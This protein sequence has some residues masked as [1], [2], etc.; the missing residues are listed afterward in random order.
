VSDLT[1]AFFVI[2]L[3]VALVVLYGFF[4]HLM[5][6]REIVSALGAKGIKAQLMPAIPNTLRQWFLLTVVSL[7]LA[8]FLM[9][10]YAGTH[11]SPIL[12][13]EQ[14]MSS[15]ENNNAIKTQFPGANFEYIHFN[16]TT[17]KW[18]VSGSNAQYKIYIEYDDWVDAISSIQ[19]TPK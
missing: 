11:G 15:I 8:A 4:K 9:G 5:K 3:V 14:V 6:Q 19:A 18:A 7:S 16:P 17:E 2:G 1:T 12:S 10:Y 13:Q